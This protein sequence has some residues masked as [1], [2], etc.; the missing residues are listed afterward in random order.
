MPEKSEGNFSRGWA[1]MDADGNG[2]TQE[3]NEF[4]RSFRLLNGPLQFVELD[5]KQFID[6]G[7]NVDMHLSALIRVNPRQDRFFPIDFH[8]HWILPS[9]P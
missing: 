4:D 6:P 8:Q 2:S 3:Q 7:C 9:R 1:R 5:G